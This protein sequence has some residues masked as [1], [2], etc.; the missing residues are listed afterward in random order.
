M[1]TSNESVQPVPLVSFIPV[2]KEFATYQGSLTVPPCS[3]VV[4]W[5]VPARTLPV[6]KVRI[7]FIFII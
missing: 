6:S 3:E 7:I 2:F 1:G 4:L 5:I